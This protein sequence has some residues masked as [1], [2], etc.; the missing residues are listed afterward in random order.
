MN[1]EL[2]PPQR[3]TLDR[4]I[5]KASGDPENLTV[6][7]GGSIAKGWAAPTSDVDVMTIVT[8]EAFARRRKQRNVAVWDESVASAPGVAADVKHVGLSWLELGAERGSEPMR[9]ALVGSEVVWCRGDAAPIQAVIE[10]VRT[11]PEAGV[12]GRIESYIAQVETMKW[13]IGEADKRSDPYLGSWVASRAVLFG[14]R[15]ILAHNRRLFPFHKWLLRA[16]DECPLKPE[17][18][19]DLARAATRAPGADSVHAFCD[20]VIGF[21]DWPCDLE[22]W[23]DIFIRDTEWKWMTGE[24]PMDE[25]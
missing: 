16:T 12:E 10:R 7:L 19:T 22:K 14:C 13:Y 24:P 3:E 21:A 4:Y 15:A 2:S 18:L 9:A 1:T 5:E 25:A 23:G 11:Y 17:G 20:A 8:E 6:I